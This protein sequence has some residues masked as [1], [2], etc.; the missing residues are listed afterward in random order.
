[1]A[2][3]TGD[4][5]RIWLVMLKQGGRW[6]NADVAAA[7]GRDN[8]W[9]ANLVHS[10]CTT[11]TLHRFGYGRGARYGVTHECRIPVGVTI[12]EVVACQLP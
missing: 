1:M 4:S 10:M 6:S 5:K 3:P 8:T 2:A 7:L 12:S 11:G 9:T